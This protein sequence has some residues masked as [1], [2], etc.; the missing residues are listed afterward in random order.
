MEPPFLT[1]RAENPMISGD[2]LDLS[3]EIISWTWLKESLV[4]F[5]FLCLTMY[6]IA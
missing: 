1:W 5:Q 6:A 2:L 4:S 3:L